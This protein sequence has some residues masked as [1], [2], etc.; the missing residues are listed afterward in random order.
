VSKKSSET[1]FRAFFLHK[2]KKKK[3]SKEKYRKKGIK[4]LQKELSAEVR[5]TSGSIVN[6][7]LGLED[8]MCRINM[9]NGRKDKSIIN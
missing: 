9:N 7:N 8:R 1:L 2:K 6:G 3:N 5:N 4:N